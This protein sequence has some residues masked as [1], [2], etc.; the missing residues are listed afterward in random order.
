MEPRSGPLSPKPWMPSYLIHDPPNKSDNGTVFTYSDGT[1]TSHQLSP[2][3][4]GN[5]SKIQPCLRH[6]LGLATNG[7]TLR[8]SCQEG[9]I[10]LL[11]IISTQPFAGLWEEW[12]NI[13]AI[14]IALAKCGLSNHQPWPTFYRSLRKALS[15]QVHMSLCRNDGA[16]PWICWVEA[17]P[18]E[19]KKL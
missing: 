5:H 4:H 17:H 19:Q 8:E 10:M 12:T 15:T 3:Y 16:D 2:K 7:K 13:L 1:I 14:R 11:K 6:M 18:P 9:P